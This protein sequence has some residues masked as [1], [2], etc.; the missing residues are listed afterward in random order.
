[1]GNPLFDRFG[2]GANAGLAAVLN[3]AALAVLY[4][5]IREHQ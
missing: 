5:L 2:I 3:L 4:R 1:V